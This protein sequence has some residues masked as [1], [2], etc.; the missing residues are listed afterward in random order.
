[1]MT[2]DITGLRKGVNV[3]LLRSKGTPELLLAAVPH[4]HL[5]DRRLRLT[6][7]D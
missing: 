3:N 6:R 1:M 5:N 4:L 7:S 2:F